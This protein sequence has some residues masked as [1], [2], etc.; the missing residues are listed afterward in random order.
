MLTVGFILGLESHMHHI[1][2]SLET[3]GVVEIFLTIAAGGLVLRLDAQVNGVH[4]PLETRFIIV[5]LVTM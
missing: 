5:L 4:V 3:G 2:V 1:N